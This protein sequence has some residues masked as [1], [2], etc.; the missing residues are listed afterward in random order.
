MA[1][2][3]DSI[4]MRLD[5]VVMLL[6]VEFFLLLLLELPLVSRLIGSAIILIFAYPFYKNFVLKEGCYKFFKQLKK[7]NYK[8]DSVN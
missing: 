1:Q 3:K 8:T 5:L 7:E 4:W 6:V 2:Y